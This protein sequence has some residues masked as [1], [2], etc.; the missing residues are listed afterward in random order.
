MA[1]LQHGSRCRR[2]ARAG[3]RRHPCRSQKSC[4][5]VFRGVV[6]GYRYYNPST[7]RWLSRDPAE[8]DEGGPNLYGFVGNNPINFWDYL[9]FVWSVTRT[10]SPRAV[11]CC[12]CGDTVAQLAAKIHLDPGDYQK[13]LMAVGG[14]ALPATANT[15]I[16][17]GACFTIPN[18]VYVNDLLSFWSFDMLLVSAARQWERLETRDLNHE[19]YDVIPVADTLSAAFL[20]QMSDAN[21]QGIVVLAHGDPDRKGDF[22]DAGPGYVTPEQAA[23]ALNHKLAGFKAIWCWSGTKRNGWRSLVSLNGYLWTKP[24][25][26]K[27]WDFWPGVIQHGFKDE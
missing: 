7:G 24:G 2:P 1:A 25:Y 9:R 12:D 17:P 3:T 8:E 26:V 18:K 21:V 16:S 10:G 15:P 4:T 14:A 6:S 13:W 20:G 19:G 27:I 22:S 5:R 11:A 23:G